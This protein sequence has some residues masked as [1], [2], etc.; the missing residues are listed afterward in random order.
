MPSAGFDTLRSSRR[1]V[2]AGR[3]AACLLALA[4]AVV[5]APALW[6]APPTLSH[7]FPAGGQR[8]SKVTVTCTGEFKWPAKVFAPGVEA[9]PASDSGKL[10]IAI[11]EDLA[12]DRV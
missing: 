11:P 12:A 2:P 5:S 7:L 6:A 1:R 9:V 8:G 4:A 10:E 3:F